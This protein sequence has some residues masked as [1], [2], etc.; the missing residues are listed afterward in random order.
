MQT[1]VGGG[2][3]T[4]ARLLQ[5][6][7]RWVMGIGKA[8]LISRFRTGMSYVLSWRFVCI[9]EI[10]FNE[11]T[12]NSKRSRNHRKEDLDSGRVVGK[13]QKPALNLSSQNGREHEHSC[14]S[15]STCL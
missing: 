7:L 8:I 14:K 12:T 4:V 6:A 11:I 9:T 15:P 5:P 3:A 1:G 10:T 13:P 2:K